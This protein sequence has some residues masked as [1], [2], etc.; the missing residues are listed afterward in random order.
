MLQLITNIKWRSVHELNRLDRLDVAR[1]NFNL[2][3]NNGFKYKNLRKLDFQFFLL[4][5]RLIA[6]KRKIAQKIRYALCSSVLYVYIILN[7]FA[8]VCFIY[9]FFRRHSGRLYLFVYMNYS[10]PRDI[11]RLDEFRRQENIS[12][13][14]MV[15]TVGIGGE[16]HVD[17]G[18]PE[19]EYTRT[20]GSSLLDHESVDRPACFICVD[21]L[22]VNIPHYAEATIL[23]PRLPRYLEWLSYSKLENESHRGEFFLAD[24]CVIWMIAPESLL[25]KLLELEEKPFSVRRCELDSHPLYSLGRKKPSLLVDENKS[26]KT[27][28]FL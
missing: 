24:K 26:A 28:S 27:F 12:K 7:Y 3:L 6:Y 15:L 4:R 18:F 14:S 5:L 19:K 1:C 22:N 23:N 17:S 20:S 10:L 9:P 13:H 25:K 2:Q 11:N 16:S 21:N 8:V